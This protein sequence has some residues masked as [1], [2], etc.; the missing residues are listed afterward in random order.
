MADTDQPSAA[1]AAA[2][3]PSSSGA[4]DI[5]KDVAEVT[6]AAAAYV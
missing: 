1:P 5:Q 6:A 3:A 4:E 2:E